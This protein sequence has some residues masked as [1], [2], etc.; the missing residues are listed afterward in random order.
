M[1][2]AE[3]MAEE[4]AYLADALI[5]TGSISFVPHKEL[6]KR[7]NQEEFLKREKL[8]EALFWS[9]YREKKPVLG[10][11][12][13]FQMMNC[14][15]GGTLEER[16]KFR[17]GVEHM[18]HQHRI[19]VSKESIWYD[20][21]G[22][23]FWV[24]SRHNDKIDVVAKELRITAWSEDGVVEAFEHRTL[25][26]YGVEW[27]PERMRGDFREPPEGPDMTE[28]FIWFIHCSYL[29]EFIC[30]EDREI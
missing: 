26:I 22:E 8:D 27:H 23:S 11:C 4:Y 20:L 17:T 19:R 6:K 16:F 30:W 24:N 13:G 12:F 21:F 5:L 2:L 15:L 3:S 25:P 28:F 7:L 10:I 1:P 18:L 29:S 14:Y 9:F